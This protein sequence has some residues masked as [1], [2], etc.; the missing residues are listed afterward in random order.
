M[1]PP[2]GGLRPG[3]KVMLIKVGD[4]FHLLSVDAP[5][6]VK[7][8]LLRVATAVLET[9]LIGVDEEPAPAQ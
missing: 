3:D 8:R 7:Q 2:D 1:L 9:E 6:A 4:L 5:E